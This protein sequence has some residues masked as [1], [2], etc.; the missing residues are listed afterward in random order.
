MNY[1]FGDDDKQKIFQL[2]LKNF[3]SNIKINS[4]PKLFINIKTKLR[5]RWITKICLHSV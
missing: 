2:W 4:S 5:K 3:I 1:C